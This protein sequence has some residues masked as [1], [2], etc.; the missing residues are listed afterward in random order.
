VNLD[1]EIVV[2]ESASAKRGNSNIKK[3]NFLGLHG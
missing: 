1:H 3:R 2:A